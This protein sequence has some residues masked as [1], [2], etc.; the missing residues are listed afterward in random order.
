MAEA[1]GHIHTPAVS[2]CV[3]QLEYCF[4]EAQS[5]WSYY[6]NLR[7]Y[8]LDSLN[9]IAIQGRIVMCVHMHNVQCSP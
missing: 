5:K 1:N 6:E 4:F 7:M 2:V 9:L 8:P 3:C